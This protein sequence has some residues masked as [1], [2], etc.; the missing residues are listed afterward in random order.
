MKN[1]NDIEISEEEYCYLAQ[2]GFFS[3]PLPPVKSEDTKKPPNVNSDLDNN[4]FYNS[5]AAGFN[6]IF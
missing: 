3:P 5:I 4:N 2:H 1:F 6:A